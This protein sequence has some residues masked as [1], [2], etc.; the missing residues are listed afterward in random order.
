MEITY[1]DSWNGDVLKTDYIESGASST[2]PNISGITHTNLTQAGWSGNYENVIHDEL[3]MLDFKSSTGN[4]YLGL[5]VNVITGYA[6]TLT[7]TKSTTDLMVVKMGDGTEYTS[8][9]SGVVN[10]PH[11]YAGDS[12]N[13]VDIA[14]D[15]EYAFITPLGTTGIIIEALVCCIIG[16]NHIT[17]TNTN[18]LRYSST[19]RN[20]NIHYVSSIATTGLGGTESLKA[21]LFNGPNIGF[22]G[23]S[24]MTSLEYIKLP[25]TVG[26]G[27]S[28]FSDSNVKIIDFGIV[29]AIGSSVLGDTTEPEIIIFN[30]TTPPV[31]ASS[32]TL[33]NINS[34]CKI[35]VPNASYLTATNMIHLADN[36]IIY[37]V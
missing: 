37:G 23:F 21:L 35:F 18:F 5:S 10:F 6:V 26:A 15:G 1:V 7:I 24:Q 30:T 4:S 3:V 36:M 28:S 22:G 25:N 13:C 2:P 12:Y 9:A 34:Q 27:N 14:C 31:F 20:L 29:E 8:S 33:A 17:A 11:V 19:L 32:T 16:V